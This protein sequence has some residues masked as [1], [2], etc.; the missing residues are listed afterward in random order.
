MHIMI[1]NDSKI[2]VISAPKNAL[3]RDV[4]CNIAI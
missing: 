1:I 3:A 2:H 4:T